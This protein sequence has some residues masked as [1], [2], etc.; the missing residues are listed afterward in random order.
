MDPLW[1]RAPRVLLRFP[2]LFAAL[3][4]GALL[5]TLAG[6]SYPLFV[7]AT[8]GE[9]VG[10]QIE[11]PLV[12]RY[13]AGVSYR[14]TNVQLTP[15]RLGGE[16]EALF[17][18]RGVA[19]AARAS[20]SPLL[21]PVVASIKG[22]IL[23]ISPADNRSRSRLGTLFAGTNVLDHVEVLAG[24][25]GPGVWLPDEVAGPLH[26]RPG[27]RIALWYQRDTGA[28]EV[29]VD[30]IYRSLYL[31][32]RSG[33]WLQWDHEIYPL[34]G[35]IC[36]PDCPPPPPFILVD[37]DQL[38]RLSAAIGRHPESFSFSWTAPLASNPELSLDRARELGRF[39][40]R[41]EADIKD[42]TTE[43]GRFLE[44]CGV[45]GVIN[46]SETSFSSRIGEIVTEGDRRIAAVQAPGGLLQAAGIGVALVVVGLAGAF[47]FAARRTEA[48]LLFARG[49]SPIAAGVKA[50]LESILPCFLG[51]VAGLVLAFGVVRGFGPDGPVAASAIADAVRVVVLALVASLILV[52]VVSAAVFP[53]R[54]EHRASHLRVLART[55]WELL[56]L[57]F[58]IFCLRRLR[59]EGSIVGTSE[60]R[61][62]SGYLV[63]FPITL[64]AGSAL[65]GARVLV[66]AAVAG[67]ARSGGLRPS[68]FLA[69]HRL[70][71]RPGLS[72]LVVAT[73]ALCLGAFVYAQT[74]VRSLEVTLEAKAKLF[75]GSD[76]QARVDPETP[77]PEGLRLPITRV[78][79]VLAAG[80]L[81]PG[82]EPFDL[83]AIDPDTFATAAYWDEHF[84]DTPL[85][86]LVRALG[87]VPG[88]Q[89]PVIV[90]G[91]EDPTSLDLP[92]RTVPVGVIAH[93]SAFPGVSSDRPL[94]VASAEA[95][96][97]AL[98]GTFDPLEQSNASTQFWIK[99]DSLEATRAIVGFEFQPDLVLT[100]DE[101]VDIPYIAAVITTFVVLNVLALSA[102]ALVI[103]VMLMHLQA[104]QRNE[105]V[106]FA[107]SLRM[108]MSE[109]DHRRA[110]TKELGAMLCCSYV[111][112]LALALWAAD[113]LIPLLDP[114]SSIPPEPLFVVPLWGATLALT[115]LAF[116][117]W[118]GSRLAIHRARATH[119][120]EVLRLAE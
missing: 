19:F 9:L 110:L 4:I 103:I 53:R 66:R 78:T 117:S 11:R 85:D 17:M 114:L 87:Q 90:A 89:M 76:V 3:A 32:G 94:V 20:E 5:L 82:G 24:R 23:S 102:G 12:T 49:M 33:Y 83:L 86:Q 115:G 84:S 111:M 61:R 46:R 91:S 30:G 75:V 96:Q 1:K 39:V 119:I 35:P 55:P 2:G 58:A 43:L 64:I 69:A 104:R 36:R 92:G 97:Q 28:M 100:A 59:A 88:T 118:I 93:A 31:P 51:A 80:T 52:G 108:G 8:A 57:A 25:E 106:S 98:A 67:R 41:F 70:A 14:H 120:G 42:P 99:G 22:P 68:S 101:V 54:V 107:L 50:S 62:P 79:R 81:S 38:F 48:N 26:V 73:G 45:E 60:V 44:C 77:L 47:A 15:S 13:G 18:R 16:S 71:G 37:Q 109:A 65:L 95:I 29:P 40:S 7:S 113:L 27:D 10:R 105:A 116:T 112:G 34:T 21:G 6:A 63:L 56:L 74:V 72:T